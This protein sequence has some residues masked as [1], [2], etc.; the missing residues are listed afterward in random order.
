[1]GDSALTSL[2]KEQIDELYRSGAFLVIKNMPPG[3]EFGIDYASWTVRV[4]GKIAG[5][6]VM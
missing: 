2:T 1:M 3:T 6:Y 5:K 4:L